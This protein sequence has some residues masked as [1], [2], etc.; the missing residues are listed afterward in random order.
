MVTRLDTY[1]V[2][3]VGFVGKNNKP[4]YIRSFDAD[5][6]SDLEM[7][8]TVHSCLDVVDERAEAGQVA[9][10]LGFLSLIGRFS[11]YGYIGPTRIKVF[12]V[13]DADFDPGP[14]DEDVSK[15]LQTLHHTYIDWLCNPFVEINLSE[16]DPVPLELNEHFIKRVKKA[17]QENHFAS[18]G[19]S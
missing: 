16:G 9:P 1:P 17:C 8:L 11:V 14:R 15:L 10:Y 3:G 19:P 12:C 7:N 6:E 2:L 4:L 5:N 18:R 13:L